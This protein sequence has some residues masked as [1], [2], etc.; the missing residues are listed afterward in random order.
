MS[1]ARPGSLRASSATTPSGVASA[2]VQ[3]HHLVAQPP[4]AARCAPGE[5]VG[6]L[7][8]A[9][10]RRGRAAAR[11]G[12]SS[13]R[14]RSRG[15]SGRRTPSESASIGLPASSLR[16]TSPGSRGRSSH[17]RARSDQRVSGPP[18]EPDVGLRGGHP[19]GCDAVGGRDEVGAGGQLDE[20]R[21]GG[22]VGVDLAGH[23][24]QVAHA[25]A[26][27]A[28]QRRRGG[29][30][31][32][33]QGLDAAQEVERGAA[34]GAVD[35]RRRRGRGRPAAAGRAASAPS[36]RSPRRASPTWRGSS[37]VSWSTRSRRPLASSRPT[38]PLGSARA[39]APDR[40]ACGERVEHAPLVRVD[41]G[42]QLRQRGRARDARG[43]AAQAAGEPRDDVARGRD[44]RP[45]RARLLGL[46]DERAGA[47]GGQG[48]VETSAGMS[49]PSSRATSARGTGAWSASATTS[50]SSDGERG[51]SR[52]S[53][54]RCT[55]ARTP[56]RVASTVRSAGGGTARS[57]RS[58]S[59][60]AS[61]SSSWARSQST[62][63]VDIRSTVVSAATSGVEEE[64]PVAKPA[65]PGRIDPTWP[66]LPDG[67]HPISELA[68]T[69]AGL[70]VAVRGPRVPAGRGALRAP[71]HGDQPIAAGLLLAAGAGR[72]MGGPKALVELDGEPLVRRAL[73]VLARRRLRAAVVVVGAAADDVRA[74]LPPD[75]A[76][77]EAA[78]WADGM[79]ASLRAGLAA[80]PDVD[81]V[82]VH[83]VDLPGV[84]AAA[85]ARLAA[86]A[87]RRRCR[88]AAYDGRPAHPVVL[89]REH[90]AGVARR[91][92]PATRA[93][94]TTSRAT[95][96]WSWWS[97]PTWPT[98]TTSTPRSARPAGAA[99]GTRT[100]SPLCTGASDRQ[101]L[102]D[103]MRFGLSRPGSW[104]E[105]LP[106]ARDVLARRRSTRGCRR[107]GRRSRRRR[108]RRPARRRAWRGR[109]GVAGGGC[110]A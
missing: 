97:A 96:I 90:W 19:F 54:A 30:P 78:D 106:A 3:R 99:D 56:A 31:E 66:E 9:S 64:D 92:R 17:V 68:A 34:G 16:P 101:V 100:G 49:G 15:A 36:G 1:S 44:Q 85:V 25:E 55:D 104:H 20:Q 69:G 62:S 94:G 72:R 22:L 67:E 95:R 70:A 39:A 65:R 91:R 86:G 105:R 52:S 63:G 8:R 107:A 83:L 110:A 38:G 26:A 42:E 14:R 33:D 71:A 109:L 6:E 43:R 51:V 81:A 61:V 53:Q 29:A 28:E 2:S 24:A 47:Q 75:V 11:R 13:T 102:A 32:R 37:T 84:T 88:R 82:L 73:R 7:G 98:P 80:L 50:A 48:A 27:R 41:G 108:G 4:A 12:P 18:G 93:R 103:R 46:P 89:G 35:G 60:A 79:G 21:G 23:P 10:R 58:R 5:D 76:A 74:V 59:R 40:R 87:A 77:V 57:G 45:E